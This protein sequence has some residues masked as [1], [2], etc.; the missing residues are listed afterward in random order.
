MI[1]IDG[2]F[3]EG[4]GQ[5]VRTAVSLSAVTGKPV[6][7]SKIRQ[8]RPKPGLAAQHVKAISALADICQA[9]TTGVKPG[10]SQIFFA[11]GKVRGGR[12]VAEIGTAGSVTLLMQCLLP[13]LLKADGPV[14]LE[15]RGGTDVKWAPSVDYFAEVFL[16]GLRSFGAEVRM[17]ILQRGYYPRGQGRVLLNVMPGD[18]KPAVLAGRDERGEWFQNI[19]AFSAFSAS[20]VVKG[21]SHSSNLPDHVAIRQAKAAELALQ[22][23][24]YE[25]ALNC[26]MLS[27]PSTGSGITLWKEGKGASC[28]GER[29]LAAEIVG[30]QAAKELILELSSSAGVDVHLADQLI[31]YLALAGGEITVRHISPH[32]STNIWTVGHFLDTKIDVNNEP[33]MGLFR[34]EC[35]TAE[36]KA[37]RR[38]SS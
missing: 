35:Q 31:V 3:G 25:A 2:S 32:T 6:R 37:D 36:L 18:L 27:L 4:G 14:S 24:G 30:K 22:E 21:I 11:P 33:D 8:G 7:V 16:P 5:I 38:Q 10:S 1:E 19:E 23:A 12:Y 29:G 34:I 17:Q 9:E 13:A 28:L 26:Q 15:A 20:S